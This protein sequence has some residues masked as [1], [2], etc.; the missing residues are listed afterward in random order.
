MNNTIIS[1]VHVN[2]YNNIFQILVAY[3]AAYSCVRFA[4]CLFYQTKLFWYLNK[5][6]PVHV[7]MRAKNI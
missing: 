3:S 1:I 4:D 7:E 6:S 5:K 2:D